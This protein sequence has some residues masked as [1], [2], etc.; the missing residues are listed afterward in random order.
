MLNLHHKTGIY[1]PQAFS[2]FSFFAALSLTIETLIL[3]LVPAD[4][5][6]IAASLVHLMVI[7]ILCGW[8]YYEKKQG[9]NLTLPI[10]LLICIGSMS[11]FGSLICL[12]TAGF[13][14]LNRHDEGGFTRWLSELFPDEDNDE[15]EALY[16]RIIF[17]LDDN[18]ANSTIEP[19]NDILVYGSLKQKQAVLVK[20]T[21]YFTPAFAPILRTAIND[22]DAAVRVQAATVITKI[23]SGYASKI[24]QLEESYATLPDDLATM[25]ALADAYR[26]YAIS[27]IIDEQAASKATAKSI[28]LYEALILCQP[29]I[30]AH[31]VTLGHLYLMDGQ[32]EKAY[33]R[34]RQYIDRFGLTSSEI[35]IGYMETLLQLKQ[36]DELRKVAALSDQYIDESNMSFNDRHFIEGIKCWNTPLPVELL[37]WNIKK[38]ATVTVLPITTPA[39]KEAAVYAVS[40]AG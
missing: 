37:H 22:K 16:E 27:G 5:K 28:E 19:F 14:T 34:F 25:H 6:L 36:Y 38:S 9:H 13:F 21:R 24:Q 3:L 35:A 1:H 30:G 4:Y 29:E 26:D 20:M 15:S 12:I 10:L 39:A 40:V 2:L 31:K 32:L 7:E 18:A 11:V 8:L 17:G 33:I 23:E